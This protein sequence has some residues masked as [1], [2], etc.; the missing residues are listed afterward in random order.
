MRRS[1]APDIAHARWPGRRPPV[2][3]ITA[4]G[5]IHL[6]GPRGGYRSGCEVRWAGRW[7][8]L[9]TLG[10][11]VRGMVLHRRRLLGLP[12]LAALAGGVRLPGLWAPG[13]LADERRPI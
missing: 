2:T 8:A 6:A 12:R 7:A 9:S 3:G 13:R 1:G 4:V 5:G 10:R 11:R